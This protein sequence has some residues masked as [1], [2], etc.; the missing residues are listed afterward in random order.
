[1]GLACSFKSLFHC[2]GRE[3]DGM[4]ADMVLEKYLGVLYLDLKVERETLG[5]GWAS[6]TSKPTYQGHTSFSKAIPT[7]AS[8]A[9]GQA[10]KY[11]PMGALLFKPHFLVLISL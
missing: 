7:P 3:Y 4:Q 6:E 10:F 2:H 8:S 9:V 1:M 11:K 5:L